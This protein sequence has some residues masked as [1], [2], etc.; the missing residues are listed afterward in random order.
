MKIKQ[1]PGDIAFNIINYAILTFLGLVCVV[2]FIHLIALSFSS[3]AMAAAGRVGLWPQAF[4]LA[5]YQYA[6]QTPLFLRAFG[7]TILRV[8]LGVS[9]N[10]VL[11][12]LT[13]YPLSKRNK[14]MP[15]RTLI[16]W[17]GEAFDPVRE[18]DELSVKLALSRTKDHSY[19]YADGKNIVK[20]LF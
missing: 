2:P 3:S 14:E 18:G 8:V 4:T 17:S 15:G 20:V 12:V 5:S 1:T 7:I 16:S 13:A 19:E 9:L 6:F 10:M 11:L